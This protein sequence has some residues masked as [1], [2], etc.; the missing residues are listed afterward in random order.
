VQVYKITTLTDAFHFNY[1]YRVSTR[2]INYRGTCHFYE[3][4][5]NSYN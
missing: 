5:S 2:I 4:P 3:L 1:E